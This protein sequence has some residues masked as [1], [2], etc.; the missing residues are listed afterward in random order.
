MINNSNFKHTVYELYIGIPEIDFFD[1]GKWITRVEWSEV[2]D[3][4]NVYALGARFP[5]DREDGII[6]A[7]ASITFLQ[8]GLDKLINMCKPLGLRT[9]FDL[10]DFN[11][12]IKQE[13]FNGEIKLTTLNLCKLTN[14]GNYNSKGNMRSEVTVNVSVHSISY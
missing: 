1:F 13:R 12:I 14:F 8:E 2:I 7:T 4:A 11:I 9:Y 6:S 10:P 5:I 3:V